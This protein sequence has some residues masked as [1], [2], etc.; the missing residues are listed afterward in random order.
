MCLMMSGL[1]GELLF[2][3]VFVLGIFMTEGVSMEVPHSSDRLFHG[4][5]VPL[6]GSLETSTSELLSVDVLDSG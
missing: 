4:D 3:F 2:L 6:F 5:L 1:F